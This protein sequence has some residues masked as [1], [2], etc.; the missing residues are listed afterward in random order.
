[1]TDE[2]II[3]QLRAELAELREHVAPVLELARLAPAEFQGLMIRA[4]QRVGELED[5]E[6]NPDLSPADPGEEAHHSR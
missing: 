1:M 4:S 5:V 2:Q 3:A 6:V